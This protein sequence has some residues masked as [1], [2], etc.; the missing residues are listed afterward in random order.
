LFKKK[1]EDGLEYFGR[2]DLGKIVDGQLYVVGLAKDLIISSA[3]KSVLPTG[4]LSLRWR[5]HSLKR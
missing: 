5:S 4:I 1:L 3:K 2:G